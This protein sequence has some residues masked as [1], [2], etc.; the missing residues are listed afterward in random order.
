MIVATEALEINGIRN[1][2]VRIG[3]PGPCFRRMTQDHAIDVQFEIL[4][5]GSAARCS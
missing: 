3:L 5:S 4:A 1:L 2:P